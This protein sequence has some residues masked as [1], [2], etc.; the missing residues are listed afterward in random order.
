[1]NTKLTVISL[2]TAL[3]VLLLPE[4][5][6]QIKVLKPYQPASAEIKKEK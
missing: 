6:A 3:S 2:I 1:M 4:A 5:D